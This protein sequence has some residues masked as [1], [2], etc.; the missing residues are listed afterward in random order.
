[1]S[2]RPDSPDAITLSARVR[3]TGIATPPGVPRSTDSGTASTV[4][5][6]DAAPQ[7]TTPTLTRYTSTDSFPIFQTGNVI[8]R[9]SLTGLS[10]QWQLH[11]AVLAR[12]STWF[13]HV[14]ETSS[15]NSEYFRTWRFFLLEEIDGKVALVLQKATPSSQ[16]LESENQG[17]TIKLEGLPDIDQQVGTLSPPSPEPASTPG[18]SPAVARDQ[19]HAAIVETYN[20]ILGAFYSVPL[21][22]PTTT[23]S[24]TVI[25]VE[26]LIK[27]SESLSCTH[28]AAASCTAALLSHH[29]KLCTS[30]SRDPAR[31]LLLAIHLR[32]AVL[33]R[34]SLTHIVGCHPTWP[35]PTPR[36]VLPPH[37]ID[38]VVRKSEELD[39]ICTETER[40]L[41]LLTI[42]MHRGPVEPD[43][44]NQFDSWFTVQLFRDT[45]A[46]GFHALEISKDKTLKRG[47]LYRQIAKGGEEYM[48]LE[49]MRELVERVMPSALQGLKEDLGL[50]KESARGIVRDVVKNEAGVDGE[51]VGWLTCVKIRREDVPWELEV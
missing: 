46:R 8:I 4:L 31:Y 7:I 5:T 9:C 17:P 51:E 33:F 24:D 42:E 49:E 19:P 44:H 23:L 13:K 1:M 6:I 3:Y 41:L 10:K 40:D 38:L 14:M 21:K 48:P 50:L 32:S 43:N 22:I 30:I 28:L 18:S 25:T 29:R 12:H 36:T 34:D 35:W 45:L 37:I 15:Q 26:S 16:S 11:G 39:R 27:I 20:Q 47:K 2:P